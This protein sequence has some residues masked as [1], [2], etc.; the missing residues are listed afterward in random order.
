M[1]VLSAA[2]SATADVDYVNRADDPATSTVR[3]AANVE[4]VTC[5][6]TIKEDTERECTETVDVKV[7]ALTSSN[8]NV[9]P[10]QGTNVM[11]TVSILDD[12]GNHQLLIFSFLSSSW[13]EKQLWRVIF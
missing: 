2:T 3:F 13:K 9:L 1:C 8:A 5:P 11:T 6:L 10:V 7:G 4:E 12:E